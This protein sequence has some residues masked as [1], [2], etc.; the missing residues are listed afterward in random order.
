M[1]L[2]TSRLALASA[3]TLAV[4]STA[5]AHMTLETSEATA[6][7]SYKAVLR[8]PHGCGDAATTTLKVKVP[9]GYYSV[10][11]MPHAGWDLGTVTGAYGNTYMNHGTPVSEGVLE[12]IWSGGNLP[13]AF[14]DEFVMNGSLSSDIA[15]GTVLYFPAVQICENGSENHWVATADAADGDPAPKLAVKAATADAGHHDHGHGDMVASDTVSIGDLVITGGFARATLPGAPVGGGF[16]TITN[17]GD[18]DDRLIAASS[19]I[20]GEVQ[21]H[22]MR[23]DGDIM[24]MYQMA[25]GIP[26]PAHST[27]KLAPG[28]LHVMFMQLNGPLVEGTTV[29]VELTFEKAGSVVVPFSVEGIASKSADHNGH[30]DHMK[31][32]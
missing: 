23:M 12:V 29:D 1:T 20:A 30:G 32:E 25:D 19:D 13:N 8:V 14:Y 22:N 15:D 3:M 27:V 2:L 21:L 24:K 11:P 16:V 5:H 28:A 7:S 17:E 10:K 18:H 4:F 6:G 26:V 31:A 9:E